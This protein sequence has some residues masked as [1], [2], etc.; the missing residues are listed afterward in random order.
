MYHESN[1]SVPSH[2]PVEAH[3]DMP[4]LL[5]AAE[6]PSGLHVQRAVR[7]RLAAGIVVFALAAPAFVGLVIWRF[8]PEYRAEANIQVN[9]FRPRVLYRTDE[10]APNQS[11]SMFLNTQ[12]AIV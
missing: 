6:H 12:L 11:Y 3:V 4:A 1:A 8:Q 7:K 10:N 9:P 5:G 2:L